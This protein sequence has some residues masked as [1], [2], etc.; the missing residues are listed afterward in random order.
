MSKWLP[1]TVPRKR[2]FLLFRAISSTLVSSRSLAFSRRPPVQV[3][4]LNSLDVSNP[5][6]KVCGRMRPS[7]GCRVGNSG[8]R[9]PTLSSLAEIFTLPVTPSL[10]YSSAA[11]PSSW[12]GN[13]P[14]PVRSGLESSLMPSMPRVSTPKPTTPSV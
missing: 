7:L 5:P 14:V 6:S 2:L 1:A 11:R 13:R 12:V 9:V 8:I 4:L 3:R 10:E